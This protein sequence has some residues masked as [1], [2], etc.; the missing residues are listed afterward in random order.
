MATPTSTP[1]PFHFTDC[2]AY[3]TD[4]FDGCLNAM[5]SGNAAALGE[6]ARL[7]RWLDAQREARQAR[8]VDPPS[9]PGPAAA[10]PVEATEAFLW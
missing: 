7:G 5:R 10:D 4:Q 3:G 1:R 9:S 6:F 8:T 2:P